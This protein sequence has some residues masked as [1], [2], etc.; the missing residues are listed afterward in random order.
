MSTY[1]CVTNQEEIVLIKLDFEKA[2]DR[3]EHSAVMDIMKHKGFGTRWLQW[4]KAIFSS[5][6]SF[7][8][9]NGVPGKR[10]DCRRG[11][12]QRDPLSPPLFVLAVDLLQSLLNQ[13]K[14]QNLLQLPIPL[15]YNQDF[16]ILQYADDTLIIMEG[17]PSQLLHFKEILQSFALSTGLKVNYNKSL[18]VPINITEVRLQTLSQL[19]GCAIGKL[20]FTYLGLPLG[21]TKPKID[22]FLPMISRCE[23]RLISTSSFLSQAGRLQLTNSIFT[24][25]P[26][27]HMCTFMLPKIAYK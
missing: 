18:V 4:M 11:V 25:L 12:R 24:A 20:H 23:R 13:A 7:I 21:L 14:I 15:S 6:T 10:F 2:F 27:F 17:Y 19:F 22:E 9:L 16:A 3:I 5:G 8:L 26:M 1:I